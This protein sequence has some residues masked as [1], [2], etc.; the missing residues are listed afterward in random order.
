MLGSELQSSE[1]AATHFQLHDTPFSFV[2]LFVYEGVLC[3]QR[4]TVQQS[5]VQWLFTANTISCLAHRLL[6]LFYLTNLA[7]DSAFV[8]IIWVSPQILRD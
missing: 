7:S 6:C 8:A 1:R 3:S 4:Q 5:L 2:C